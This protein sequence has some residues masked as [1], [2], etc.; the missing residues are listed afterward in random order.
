MKCECG[1]NIDSLNLGDEAVLCEW[2]LFPE[3]PIYTVHEIGGSVILGFLNLGEDSF[4]LDYENISVFAPN[5]ELAEMILN[6]Y[7]KNLSEVQG[8]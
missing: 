2:C 4:V 7:M 1:N 3:C 8:A 5:A 6:D